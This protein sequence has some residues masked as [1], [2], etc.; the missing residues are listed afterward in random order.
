MFPSYV[1]L[2]QHLLQCSDFIA[3]HRGLIFEMTNSADGGMEKLSTRRKESLDKKKYISSDTDHQDCA[4]IGFGCKRIFNS[5]ISALDHIKTCFFL[6]Q[7]DLKADTVRI[8][9]A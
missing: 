1:R 5:Y 6:S 4:C 8:L 9:D 2:C 3:N 7:D